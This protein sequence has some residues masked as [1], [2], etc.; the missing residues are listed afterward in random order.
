LNYKNYIESKPIGLSPKHWENGLCPNDKN[1]HPVTN[2]SWNDAVEYCVWLSYLTG[3]PIRLPME[4]E[5]VL[6]ALGT[7]SSKFPWGNE[8]NRNLCNMESNDT[9]PV[10]AFPDGRSLSGCWDMFGNVNEWCFPS[11]NNMLRNRLGERSTMPILGWS[12]KDNL[13]SMSGSCPEERL[14]HS[15]YDDV[16]FR[17]VISMKDIVKLYKDELVKES[18]GLVWI[19]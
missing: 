9:T 12:F 2:I 8:P 10:N 13:R 17:I 4:S 19:R 5:W 6:A 15:A 18:Y 7:N 1:N 11:K 3:Y 14:I 16:G